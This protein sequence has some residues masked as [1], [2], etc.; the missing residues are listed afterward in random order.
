T[1]IVDFELY[2][3]LQ[4]IFVTVKRIEHA[5]RLLTQTSQKYKTIPPALGK[6]TETYQLMYRENQDNFRRFITLIR[7]RGQ[8]SGR[9]AEASA[10][11]LP[12]INDVLG[13]ERAREIEKEIIFN[14]IDEVN[15][16]EEAVYLVGQLF[17]DFTEEEVRQFYK[18]A[19][20]GQTK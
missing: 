12:L 8:I 17:P 6:D 13:S 2:N 5:E 7:D 11:A 16:E 19:T 18:E 10:N 3:A 9:I 15:N 4:S 14:N 1:E 20:A